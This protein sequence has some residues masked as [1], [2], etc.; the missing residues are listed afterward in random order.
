MEA[1]LV[2]TKD[3]RRWKR[4]T[5]QIKF[6]LHWL[7]SQSFLLSSSSST[8][9]EFEFYLVGVPVSY[10]VSISVRRAVNE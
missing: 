4:Y 2:G 6:L 8:S 9:F 7:T 1:R 5:E 3:D 10:P